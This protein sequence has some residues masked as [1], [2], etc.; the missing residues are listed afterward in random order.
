MDTIGEV[1]TQRLGGL[2][3]HLSGTGNGSQACK[4][5]VDCTLSFSR[6]LLTLQ[7]L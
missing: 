5:R 4:E 1:L 6:H 7:V 2:H 3:S